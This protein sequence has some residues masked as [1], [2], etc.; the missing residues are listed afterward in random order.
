MVSSRRAVQGVIASGL[1]LG[2]AL[3]CLAQSGAPV[4]EQPRDVAPGTG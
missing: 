4:Q 3:T 2:T 1:L